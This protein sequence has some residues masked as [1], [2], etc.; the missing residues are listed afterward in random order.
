MK[1]AIEDKEGKV[2]EYLQNSNSEE[3][4]LI[5]H[6]DFKVGISLYECSSWLLELM[7]SAAAATTTKFSN[8]WFV[9]P[10]A[11]ANKL[12]DDSEPKI[13]FPSLDVSSGYYP[14]AS[15]MMLVGSFK[16]ADWIASAGL[17]NTISI[18]LQPLDTRY[19]IEE[20]GVNPPLN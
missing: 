5:T 12:W 4:W 16:D 18:T 3:A 7:R 13:N 20:E 19:R 9:H 15:Y 2:S 17:E 11:G 8:V 10:E 6:S 1:K 14:T